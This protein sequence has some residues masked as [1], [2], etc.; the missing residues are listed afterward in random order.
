MVVCGPAWRWYQSRHGARPSVSVSRGWCIQYPAWCR[1]RHWDVSKE[2]RQKQ[3]F[4][5][6]WDGV[7]RAQQC[8]VE[9]QVRQASAL[10][11]L[12]SM[13]IALQRWGVRCNERRVSLWFNYISYIPMI[14][15]IILYYKGQGLYCPILRLNYLLLLFQ[16]IVNK[17]D[18]LNLI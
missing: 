6:D 9:I 12:G 3:R 15:V 7:G 16:F 4:S 5:S 17:A 1:A 10:A 8:R 14:I 11:T 2:W 18:D 13:H